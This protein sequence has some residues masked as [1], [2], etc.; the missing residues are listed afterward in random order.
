M[1]VLE[2]DS[3]RKGE[4]GLEEVKELGTMLVKLSRFVSLTLNFAMHLFSVVE[5]SRCSAKTTHSFG[6]GSMPKFF[7]A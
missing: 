6:K 7:L 1:A 3:F 5:Y 4:E 2:E